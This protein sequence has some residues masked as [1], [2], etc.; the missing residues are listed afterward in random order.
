MNHRRICSRLQQL[1]ELQHT[2]LLLVEAVWKAGDA[3]LGASK[4]CEQMLSERC[5]LHANMITTRLIAAIY[6][7]GHTTVVLDRDGWTR[8][9]VVLALKAYLAV[10]RAGIKLSTRSPYT[11]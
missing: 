6:E 2:S 10:P 11:L 4:S 9:T 8:Q 7:D 3:Y 1:S 5:E